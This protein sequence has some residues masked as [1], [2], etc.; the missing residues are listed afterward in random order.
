M[1]PLVPSHLLLQG[2]LPVPT[3]QPQVSVSPEALPWAGTA[4]L[5][6]AEWSERGGKALPSPPHTPIKGPRV[7]LL[8]P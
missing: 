1:Y 2:F 5:S 4:V 6:V 3:S 8:V 7:V